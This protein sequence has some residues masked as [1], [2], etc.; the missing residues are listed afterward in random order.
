MSIFGLVALVVLPVL[1]GLIAWAGDVIGYRLGKS[2]RSLF[3]LRPRTT[4][5]LIGIAVGVGL[6][7]VGLGTALLGSQYARQALFELDQLIARQEQ[8]QQQ[9]RELESKVADAR[10]DAQTARRHADQLRAEVNNRA[11]EALKARSRLAQAQGRLRQAVG[12]LNRLTLDVK[13][14]RTARAALSN[15]KERLRVQLVDLGNDL[16]STAALLKSS[17]AR[18]KDTDTEL[19]RRNAS[20][21]SKQAELER[22]QVEMDRREAALRAQRRAASGP[23]LFE[24]GH[25]LVR[26]IL[27]VPETVEATATAL[28]QLLAGADQAVHERSVEAGSEV[29][30]AKL[31]SPEPPT[32]KPADPLPS[33]EAIV[34]AFAR[35]L[36]EAGGKQVVGVRIDPRFRIFE[37]ED[38]PARVQLWMRPYVKVFSQGEVIY[39]ATIDGADKRTEIFNQLW[40]LVTKLVRREAR[41]KGLLPHPKTGEYGSLASDQ[42]LEALDSIAAEKRPVR[43]EVTAARDTYTPDPLVI[44]IEVKH[45]GS[46]YRSGLLRNRG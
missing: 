42:L 46:A 31:I 1:G 30:G 36:Q 5:R 3:G 44:K 39:A 27:D 34:T 45:D 37:G 4:A 38:V 35:Q 24:P 33:P 28:V 26:V 14:L 32:W 10:R 20:L 8:L 6:P 41:E 2:R 22:L 18:L 25:E 11:K 40:N 16:K 23:V 19:E 13:V 29:L 21:N 15:A 17:E 9:N 7:L 12:A 43:V